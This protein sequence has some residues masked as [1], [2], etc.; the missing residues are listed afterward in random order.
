MLLLASFCKAQTNVLPQE[1]INKKIEIGDT[2]IICFNNAISIW[3]HYDWET[4]FDNKYHNKKK[5]PNYLDGY[6]AGYLNTKPIYDKKGKNPIF[7]YKAI[8]GRYTPSS[9]ISLKRMLLLDIQKRK[10]S[11]RVGDDFKEYKLL[12]IEDGDTLL[13]R[14]QTST[15]EEH[16][17]RLFDEI[18][19]PLLARTIK[20]RIVGKNYLK[21]VSGD[22]TLIY[23]KAIDV[24]WRPSLRIGREIVK[25]REYY[26][27]ITIT[28]VDCSF[29]YL[30]Q[31][32]PD[33]K[34]WYKDSQGVTTKFEYQYSTLNEGLFLYTMDDID[35]IELTN[36]FIYDSVLAA[37]LESKKNEGNYHFEL[38]KVEKPKHNNIRKGTIKQGHIYEDNYIS[39]NWDA[40]EYYMRFDFALKNMTNNTMKLLWDE[41]LIVNFDGFT[42]RVIH[43]GADLEALQKAQQPAIIPSLAQ[44]A[45]F[46]CS[47]KYFGDRKPS[48]GYGGYNNGGIN[49]DR[50]M[51]LILPVQ[52][53]ATTYTYSFTFTLKW[54]WK[55]PELRKQ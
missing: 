50:E 44:M 35:S 23:D 33:I 25:K 39:I 27:F 31:S 40:H 18:K 38:T 41:A 48:E 26:R 55:H 30:W 6:V 19:I 51:R 28:D 21:R 43:K 16:K 53:G 46:Y 8:D 2:I 37:R 49:A 3:P 42:E 20:A 36:T 11:T 1:I 22:D 24:V 9:A 14:Y 52:V 4:T 15:L 32:H 5:V 13:M 17:I 54:E 29:K 34:I 7:V 12:N 45:D 47:E 10:I